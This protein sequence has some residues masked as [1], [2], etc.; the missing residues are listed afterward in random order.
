M[1]PE[2]YIGRHPF[3]VQKIQVAIRYTLIQEVLSGRQ[4][5]VR[6]F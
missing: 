1:P 4:V 6:I 3:V 2:V 5:L